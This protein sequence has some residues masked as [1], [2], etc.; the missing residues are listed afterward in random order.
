MRAYKTSLFIFRRDLRL[1]DNRALIQALSLSQK[2]YCAFIVDPMFNRA[3]HKRQFAKAALLQGLTALEQQLRQHNAGLM[4]LEGR[5][6]QVLPEIIRAQNIEAVFV[7][8]EYTPA[9]QRRDLAIEQLCR[10]QGVGWHSLDDV[11]LFPPG[12]ILKNDGNPYTVFTPFYKRCLQ[13]RVESAQ[14]LPADAGRQLQ[15]APASRRLQPDALYAYWQLQA[16]ALALPPREEIISGLGRY[17]QYDKLRDIPAEAHTSRLSAYLKLGLI[18]ARQAYHAIGCALGAESPLLRQLYWRDFFTHIGYFFPHVFGH[19]FRRQYEAIRWAD[20]H[21]HFQ[22]WCEGRTGFPLV[23][24]G[25]RELAQTGYMH[26][27]VRMVVASFLVKDLHIDWRWGEAWFADKLVDYDAAVNNG[28][29]QWAAS[30]GCDAQ[31]YFRIFNPWRQQQKFDP[32]CRYIYQWLPELT[33]YSPQQLHYWYEQPG[34]AG[35]PAPLVDHASQA[36]QAKALFA[37][38]R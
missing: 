12:A 17:N 13:F 37:A 18:S 24:A 30:T 11:C 1:E 23:D 6:Q 15:R 35:Y 16:G 29:W 33:A 38:A 21:E 34:T 3:P 5:P 32:D 7:N 2:V 9:G 14:P 19:A 4:I 8:R 31:P 10:Q 22:A 20:N 25:M 26:N 27:R 36:A 28:N